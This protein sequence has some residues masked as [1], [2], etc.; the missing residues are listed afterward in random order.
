LFRLTTTIVDLA[1]QASS[2]VFEYDPQTWGPKEVERVT[3]PGGWHNPVEEAD[4][5]AAASP[6]EA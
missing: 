6:N 5:E 3:P 2:P 4:L 1:L